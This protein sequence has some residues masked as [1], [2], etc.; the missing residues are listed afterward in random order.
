V[1]RRTPLL[2]NA[3][4]VAT[5][6]ALSEVAVQAGV[7]VCMKVRIG[8]ALD[9]RR[10]GLSDEH[11]AYATR[12]HFDFLIT[13][14]PENRPQFVVEFDGERHR[15]DSAQRQRDEL[16]D[17]IAGRLG[18]RVLR[19]DS[20]FLKRHGRFTLLGL[21]VEVWAHE[22]AFYEAQERGQVPH[23]EPYCYFSVLEPAPGGGWRWAFSVDASAR[24]LFARAASEGVLAN[25]VPE[26]RDNSSAFQPSDED[27]I[28]AYAAVALAGGNFIL[29]YARLKNFGGF[30]GI[31]ARELASDVAVADA[32]DL[33]RRYL[34]GE[35]P[36]TTREE[37]EQLNARTK[38][39]RREGAPL[40]DY[41]FSLQDSRPR[42][43]S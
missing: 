38:Q 2:V 39:W 26:V 6:A 19:I 27:E 18:L 42:S 4:E 5:D 13:D 1:D 7:R 3:Y 43:S 15:S 17:S 12:A 20:S 28:E 24:A 21:L 11:F 23:D 14:E 41:S 40:S 22:R 32:G 30:G 29:G 16:K 10:S 9:L 33:L 8:D 31:S 34:D 35:I 37:F 25:Y 36:P